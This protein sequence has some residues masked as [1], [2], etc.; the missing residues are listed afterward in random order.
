MTAEAIVDS[1]LWIRLDLSAALKVNPFFH[2]NPGNR[3][4]FAAQLLLYDRI[5]IPTKDFGIVPILI[6]WMGL[7]TFLDALESHAI[8]FV[9]PKDMLGYAGAGNG[10]SGYTILDTAKKPF[11]WYEA[12]VFGPMEASPELQLKYQCPFI[13]RNERE[14]IS[15][16]ILKQSKLLDWDNDL[17]MKHIVNESYTDIMRN[18]ILKQFVMVHEP[19]KSKSAKLNELCGVKPNQFRVPRQDNIQNGVDLVLRV[20]EINLEIMMAHLYGKADIGTSTGAEVL[21]KGKLAR[22]GASTQLIEKFINLL[23][24]ENIPDIRP[25]V[26]SGDMSLSEIWKLRMRKEATQFRQWLREANPADAREL[27]KAYIAT[28]GESTVCSSLPVKILRFIITAT[29]G[30]LQPLIGATVGVVDSFFIEKWLSGYSPRLFLDQL[31]SL[32][33]KNENRK[34]A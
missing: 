15:G 1:R 33:L 11:K 12:A 4:H 10:I 34:N 9:R 14:K 25:A 3:A 16:I 29:A 26:E 6:S 24:L 17:F 5:V 27:E 13:S 19:S 18:P 7:S 8:G 22:S 32:P 21:I 31:R 28:L 30:A 20:A 23:E 2:T